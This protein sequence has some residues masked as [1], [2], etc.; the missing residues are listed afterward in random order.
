MSLLQH[1]PS[2]A[3]SSAP[4]PKTQDQIGAC[5]LWGVGG[6][7]VQT[8]SRPRCSATGVFVTAGMRKWLLLA[9]TWQLLLSKDEA[10][11]ALVPQ[12][13]AEKRIGLICRWGNWGREGLC[14]AWSGL[15]SESLERPRYPPNP[16][17]YWLPL[18]W[19]RSLH[20]RC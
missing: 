16:R 4:K 12:N 2:K 1:L 20:K 14:F 7:G 11:G 18:W 6:H 15:G 3:G 8:T 10:L 5:H 17:F 13:A 9:G 19:R